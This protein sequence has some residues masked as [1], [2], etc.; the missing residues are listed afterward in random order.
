MRKHARTAVHSPQQ[1]SGARLELARAR[2]NSRAER[3]GLR[4]VGMSS[5]GENDWGFMMAPVEGD[6][7]VGMVS[8]NGEASIRAVVAT[9]LV[10]GA[11]R[12]QK[13]VL[14]L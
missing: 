4:R 7:L 5:V 11:C 3:Q 12:M 2:S 9:G 1:K 6:E 10:K 13:T 14:P 8:D